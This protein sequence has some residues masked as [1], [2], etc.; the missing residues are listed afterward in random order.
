MEWDVKKHTRK[1]GGAAGGAAG[2]AGQLARFKRLLRMVVP[3]QGLNLMGDQ[4][5][6]GIGVGRRGGGHGGASGSGGGL[7]GHR[8]ERVRHGRGQD[9]VHAAQGAGG[10]RRQPFVDARDVERVVAFGQDAQLL[11]FF[12]LA[13]AH[14]ALRSVH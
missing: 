9:D 14:A 13:Q 1:E 11:A 8:H 12:K 10:R 3:L 2:G 5:L 6:H 7:A 4:G